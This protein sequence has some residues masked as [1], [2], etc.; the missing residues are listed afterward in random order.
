MNFWDVLDIS[1]FPEV[2]SVKSF[3]NLWGNSYK[4]CLLPIITIPFTCGD[5]KIL[6]N[7]KMSQNIMPRI[8]WKI[9][10]CFI[11]L[12]QQLQLLKLVIFSAQIYFIFLEI[13]IHQLQMLS[14]PNFD[15]SEKIGKS[16]SQVNEIF[17]PFCKLVALVLD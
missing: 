10:F 11:Y 12:N 13:V 2:L 4:P 3:G 7:I 8:V 6:S 9:L 5:T 1:W 17:A 16:S 14:I 15:L